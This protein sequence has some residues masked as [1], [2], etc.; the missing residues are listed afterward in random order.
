MSNNWLALA[1]RDVK[2][3]ENGFLKNTEGGMK[4]IHV[5]T[6]INC[7]EDSMEKIMN[8]EKITQDERFKI[9]IAS[10]FNLL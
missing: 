7:I 8:R 9:A 2:S 5:I 6:S 10:R 1:D 3:V 4:K